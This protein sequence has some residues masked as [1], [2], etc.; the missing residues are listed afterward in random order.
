MQLESS[1]TKNN[2]SRTIENKARFF[3][4]EVIPKVYP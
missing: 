4:K 1:N 2:P 3:E